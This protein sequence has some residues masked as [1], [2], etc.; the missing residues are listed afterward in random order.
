MTPAELESTLKALEV[1]AKAGVYAVPDGAS[2]TLHV[3][4]SGASLAVTRV[5]RLR[6]E[7]DLVVAQ[8]PKAALACRLADLFAV[9]REGTGP[10]G[11]RPAGF[12]V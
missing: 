2:L 1:T 4:H 9:G 7:G 8:S 6:I 10:E 3:A 5:E 12:G 11:R